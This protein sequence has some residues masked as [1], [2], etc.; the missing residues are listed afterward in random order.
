MKILILIVFAFILYS[1]GTA[2]FYLVKDKGQGHN[3][4]RFLTVRIGISVLLFLF[5]ILA[6]H[7]GWIQPHSMLPRS[8]SG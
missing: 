4:V 1:L 5:I 3:T 2:M 7:M 6:M 8:T